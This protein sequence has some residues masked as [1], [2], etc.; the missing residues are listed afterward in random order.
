MLDA[1]HL[2][3]PVL[4][5]AETAVRMVR[6]YSWLLDH[7]GAEGIKLTGAGYLPPAHVEAAT[8]ALDL[9]GEWIGKGNREVQTLPVLHLRE[10]AT[11]MGLLRKQ[12]GMLLA[13]SRGRGRTATRPDC[14]GIS[15]NGCH[16]G[17]LTAA[18][19][20]PGFSCSR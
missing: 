3:E 20:R 13:T 6:P 17:Q 10:S 16:P 18:K 19:R 12:H 15:R 1:A 11:K 2:D 8:A 4:V 5:D 7:V 9:G 14:G